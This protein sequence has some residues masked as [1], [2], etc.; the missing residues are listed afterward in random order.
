MENKFKVG[1]IWE[2]QSMD[3]VTIT[4]VTDDKVSISW[5]GEDGLLTDLFYTGESHGYLYNLLRDGTLISEFVTQTKSRS[6]TKRDIIDLMVNINC[7]TVDRKGGSLYMSLTE[8]NKKYD[9]WKEN[10][11]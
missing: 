9:Q 7:V 3:N 10:L 6:I 1:Q 11:K 8:I 2:D 4:S 5:Q